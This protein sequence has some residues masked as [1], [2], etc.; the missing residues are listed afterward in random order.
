MQ[1]LIKI[2]LHLG[3]LP[4]LF[5]QPC[6]A[7]E[8][9]RCQKGK[10]IIYQGTPCDNPSEQE[11]IDSSTFPP[12]IEKPP[13]DPDYLKDLAKDQSNNNKKIVLTRAKDLHFY[14]EG[15]VNGVAVHFVVDTGASGI[16]IPQ[17]IADAAGLTNGKEMQINE[18]S[19]DSMAF[20]TTIKQLTLDTYKFYDIPAVIITGSHALLG[21]TVLSNFEITQKDDDMMLI[22]SPKN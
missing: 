9:F 11:S 2:I 22:Y 17:S 10:N 6:S 15:T 14:V 5:L 7:E 8:I 3:L 1:L 16:A 13:L 18:A 21:M 12:P 19:G 20:E 4:F